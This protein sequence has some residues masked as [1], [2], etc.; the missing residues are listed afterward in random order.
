[1]PPMR[2]TSRTPG[3]QVA[4]PSGDHA[5]HDPIPRAKLQLVLAVAD[6]DPSDDSADT[7]DNRD[8]KLHSASQKNLRSHAPVFLRYKLAGRKFR[9]FAPRHK[10]FLQNLNRD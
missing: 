6:P 2:L 7:G 10:R 8:A 9:S 1:M 5:A 4:H 3:H